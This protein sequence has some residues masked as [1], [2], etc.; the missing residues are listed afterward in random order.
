MRAVLFDLGGTLISF[1][2]V[3]SFRLFRA[4]ARRT[5]VFLRRTGQ[6]TGRFIWYFWRNFIAIRLRYLLSSIT[7]KDFDSLA[8]L[9]KIGAKKGIHLSEPQWERFAWLWYEPLSDVAK[10]EPDIIQTL[11]KLKDAGLKLGII[12]NTFINGL[13]LDK[14]LAKLGI[15]NFLPV[16]VYSYNFSFRKPDPR[17]FQAA[18]QRIGCAP[19]E[20]VFV[21]DSINTD[22]KG[23]LAA[24]M[25]AVLKTTGK[26][27]KKKIPP[28]VA[29]I[30]TIAQLPEVIEK[31]A[32]S[33]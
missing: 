17:I 30:Q 5:F 8:L 22:I 1:G 20:A 10:I 12:S 16:R 15:L 6:P 33:E 25:H 11:T 21:G 4:A 24:G 23:A 29:R 27:A 9:K 32:Y 2:R 26:N 3:D 7:K 18:A 31:I 28:S 13:S 19:A 14:H